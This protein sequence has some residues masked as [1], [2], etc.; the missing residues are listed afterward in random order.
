MLYKQLI[1][2]VGQNASLVDEALHGGLTLDAILD[3]LQAGAR[4][5]EDGSGVFIACQIMKKVLRGLR[6]VVKPSMS[7]EEQ[8]AIRLIQIRVLERI[9]NAYRETTKAAYYN[10]VVT[11]D[12]KYQ[13]FESDVERFT[14]RSK[15]LQE[16]IEKVIAQWQIAKIS[17]QEVK[18]CVYQNQK[19]EFPCF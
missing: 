15:G 18:M 7:Q 1:W 12:L 13:F 6:L 14:A 17:A 19:D 16:S 5:N 9:A 10:A 11:Q 3:S 2:L 4:N 8:L